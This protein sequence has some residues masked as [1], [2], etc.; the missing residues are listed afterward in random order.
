MYRYARTSEADILR[1][2]YEI[3]KTIFIDQPDNN[4]FPERLVP[5]WLGKLDVE[6]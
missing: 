3:L 1:S 6:L 2:L 4:Q 5:S